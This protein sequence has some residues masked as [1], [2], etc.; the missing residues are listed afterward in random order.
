M[1]VTAY[2]AG[3]RRRSEAAHRLPAL[4]TGHADPWLTQL[5]RD[6]GTDPNADAWHAAVEHLNRNGLRPIIPLAA[7]RALWRAGHRQA[8]DHAELR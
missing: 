4:D 1:T 5:H 3:C 8:L 7:G 2:I 6:D